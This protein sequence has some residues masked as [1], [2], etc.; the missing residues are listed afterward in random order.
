MKKILPIFMMIP[1]C[2]FGQLLG[3]LKESAAGTIGVDINTVSDK[4]GNPK[5]KAMFFA[6]ADITYRHKRV[7]MPA[8]LAY[9]QDL[10]GNINE[11]NVGAGLGIAVKPNVDFIW[12]FWNSIRRDDER[13]P[14]SLVMNYRL[15]KRNKR[16]DPFEIIPSI[17]FG[18]NYDFRA[19]KHKIYPSV[20]I[21]ATI[22]KTKTINKK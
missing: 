4:I 6:R 9:N 2:V 13:F 16:F 8:R 7:I 11:F 3:Q 18:L 15:P 17:E 20:R 14:T 19:P 5:G 12:L 10:L 1:M 21:A 22:F